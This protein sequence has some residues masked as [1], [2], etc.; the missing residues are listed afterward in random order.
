[1]AEF[2]LTEKQTEAQDVLDLFICNIPIAPGI[3]ASMFREKWDDT[4]VWICLI[5][6]TTGVPVHV[7]VPLSELDQYVVALIGRYSPETTLM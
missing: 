4:A 1:M 3:V 6:P 7:T 5:E 2:E